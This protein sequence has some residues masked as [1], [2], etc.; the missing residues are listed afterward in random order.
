MSPNNFRYLKWRNPEPY[1]GDFFGGEFSL[2]QFISVSTFILSTRYLKCLVMMLNDGAVLSVLQLLGGS[3]RKGFSMI[4]AMELS[5]A[6]KN[7]EGLKSI[8]KID[9]IMP[10]FIVCFNDIS[11]TTFTTTKM[12]EFRWNTLLRWYLSLC[13]ITVPSFL[14]LHNSLSN[15]KAPFVPTIPGQY[16]SNEKSVWYTNWGLATFH[17]LYGLAMSQAMF[18]CQFRKP[19]NSW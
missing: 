10:L 16:F 19:G 12:L 13:F 2:T 14:H 1:K 4:L 5:D 18:S 7:P 11:H 3:K 8:I 9:H 17:F 6:E 15:Q